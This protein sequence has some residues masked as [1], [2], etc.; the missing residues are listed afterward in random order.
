MERRAKRRCFCDG[1]DGQDLRYPDV[2]EGMWLDCNRTAQDSVA[3]S[4]SNAT[5]TVVIIQ[6]SA[7]ISVSKDV[8]KDPFHQGTI[9]R[10]EHAERHR[11]GHP[12]VNDI[13]FVGREVPNRAMHIEEIVVVPQCGWERRK[14]VDDRLHVRQ[15]ECREAGRLCCEGDHSS[16]PSRPRS[17]ST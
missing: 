7:W 9:E 2:S 15:L 12:V 14:S 6:R 13:P 17:A 11:G 3:E 10:T 5:E 8:N 1:Y 16:T 4:L